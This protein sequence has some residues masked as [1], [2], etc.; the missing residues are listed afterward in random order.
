VGHHWQCANVQG[1]VGRVVHHHKV[2]DVMKQ[3]LLLA[4]ASQNLADL[5]GD[6]FCVRHCSSSFEFKLDG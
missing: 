4:D 1:D 5:L 2:G 3:R 6:S